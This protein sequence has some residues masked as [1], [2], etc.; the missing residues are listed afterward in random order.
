MDKF[1]NK[2]LENTLDLVQQDVLQWEYDEQFWNEFILKEVK[3]G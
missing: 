2:E 1:F 3:N